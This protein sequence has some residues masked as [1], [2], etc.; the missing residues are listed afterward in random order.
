MKLQKDFN[1]YL[2]GLAVMNFKLHNLHWNVKGV[3]F[4]AI[5]KFT[6]ELY[7]TFFEYF[8]AVAEHEKIFGV[9]P[10]CKLADYMNNSKIK[11][12]E[13]KDFSAKEALEIIRDD[14]KA[15]RDEALALRKLS[16]ESDY[17]EAVTLFEE[18]IGYYNK[19]LWF[20]S[21]TLG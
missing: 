21:A 17:F 10:D 19:Q 13:P 11:E 6:E 14:L 5:H 2:A 18:H 3:E 9:M 1:Q 15:L 12:V 4:M 20:V 8:D 7:D 16:E